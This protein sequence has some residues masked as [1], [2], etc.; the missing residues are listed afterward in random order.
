M[1]DVFVTT[2]VNFG[3]RPAWCIAIEAVWEAAEKFS[4][5]KEE[6]AWFL[7]YRTYVDNVTGGAHNKETAMKMSQD[8]QDSSDLSCLEGN[9]SDRI[10]CRVL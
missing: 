2:Q 5:G 6:A 4:R 7:R 10:T 8:T 9:L 1:P 3:N